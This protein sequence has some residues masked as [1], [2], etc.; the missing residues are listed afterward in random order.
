MAGG[1]SRDAFDLLL[2][3]KLMTQ[4]RH[5]DCREGSNLFLFT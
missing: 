1:G 4:V 5:V 3:M 2:D